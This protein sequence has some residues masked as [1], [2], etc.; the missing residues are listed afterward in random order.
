M[1]FLHTERHRQADE[2]AATNPRKKFDP[3]IY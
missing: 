2:C 3:A 1:G